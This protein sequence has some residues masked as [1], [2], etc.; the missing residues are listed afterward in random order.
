MISASASSSIVVKED[1]MRAL[2]KGLPVVALESTVITHGIPRPTN[3]DLAETMEAAVRE[4]G[5]VPATVAIM[6]GE[7]RIGL[8]EANLETLAHHPEPVKVSLRDLGAV[9]ARG[10]TGGT[11]VAGTML[12]SHLVG[13]SVFA[14]GGLGGVHRGDADDA[15]AD[16]T[17]LERIP[18][19]V[20][21]AGA[22]SILDLP[23]TLERL[24]TAGVPVIGWGTDRF[25]AFFSRDSGLAV[26]VRADSAA[27]IAAILQRGWD[28]GLE[29]GAVVAVPIPEGDAIEPTIIETALQQALETARGSGIVGKALTP[30]LLGELH[31]LTGGETVAAN[32]ALLR[33]NAERAS[34]LAIALIG[35]GR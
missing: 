8:S 20:V 6:D 35:Q 24:E 29:A 22:K 2:D 21:C 10:A 19:A 11:T 5:A 27:E 23:R 7:L 3:L 4:A 30:F 9:L 26:S 33:H 16:L 28:L 34:E 14:T 17:A 15:S 32:L 1:V 25:P 13:I 12:A 18:V 31:R